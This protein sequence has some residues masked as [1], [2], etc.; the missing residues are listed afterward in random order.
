MFGS[1]IKNETLF[2]NDDLAIP[3]SVLKL[4]NFKSQQ[5]PYKGKF[6]FLYK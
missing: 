2:Y 3:Q 4:K 1:L 6:Q 5:L